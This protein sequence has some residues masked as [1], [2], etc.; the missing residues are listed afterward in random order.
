MVSKTSRMGNS[1]RD[2]RVP[3]EQFTPIYRRRLERGLIIGARPGTG[4]ETQM[5]Y[6]FPFGYSG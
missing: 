2:W 5:I 1:V 3:F 6:S 4:T